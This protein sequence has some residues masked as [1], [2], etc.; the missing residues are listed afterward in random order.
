[1]KF[2]RRG[3]EPCNEHFTECKRLKKCLDNKGGF[4]I[5]DRVTYDNGSK[6]VLNGQKGTVVFID[7]QEAGITVSFDRRMEGMLVEE[8]TKPH[9]HNCYF[10]KAA[11]LHKIIVAGILSVVITAASLLTATAAEG[12]GIR[13]DADGEIRYYRDGSPVYAGVVEADGNLYYIN[14][15]CKAVRSVVY[16]IGA[17]RTNGLCGAGRYTA[18]ENGVLTALNGIHVD[19]DGIRYYEDGVAVYAGFVFGEDGHGY[20]IGSSRK[21]VTGKR[22]AVSKANGYELPEML[23][24]DSVGRAYVLEFGDGTGLYIVKDDASPIGY[25]FRTEVIL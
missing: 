11:N 6:S 7:G 4:A 1:M 23:F 12:D 14:S 24:F 16:D 18:D 10:A 21:A 25:G 9:I 3:A 20:Y 19:A 15:T 17:G 8:R 5:G 13:K 2:K 22:Y